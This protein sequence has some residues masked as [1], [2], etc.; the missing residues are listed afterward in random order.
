MRAPRRKLPAHSRVGPE[1][2]TS[3]VYI[4]LEYFSIR[5][6]VGGKTK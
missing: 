2:A 3:N 6:I 1:L 4:G 5:Y